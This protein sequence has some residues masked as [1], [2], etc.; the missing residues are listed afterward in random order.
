MGSYL[1]SS[2]RFLYFNFKFTRA[3]VTYIYNGR[4]PFLNGKGVKT[5]VLA[6]DWTQLMGIYKLE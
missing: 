1:A 3:L 5:N 2:Y 4:Q 6:M